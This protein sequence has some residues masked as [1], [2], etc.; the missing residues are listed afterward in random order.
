M[1][2]NLLLCAI[3][4]FVMLDAIKTTYALRKGV[5]QRSLYNWHAPVFLFT[6]EN[7]AGYLQQMNSVNGKKVLT[8]ASSGDH[9]FECM[10]NGAQHIDTFDVNYLQKHVVELKSK[11]IKH[12]SYSDF[13]RFFFDKQSFFSPEII[14]PIWHTFSPGLK[15]FLNKYYS[16]GNNAMFRY[17]KS[18]SSF[19]NVD[20][21]TYIQDPV[22]YEHLGR[23]MPDN[24]N[25]KRTDLTNITN[26]FEETY[27]TILLSNISEYTYEELP[28]SSAKIQLFYDNILMPIAD[29][30]LSKNGG[31]I[32]FNYAWHANRSEFSEIIKHI[33]NNKYS[34]IDCFD[35][36][37]YDIEMVAVPSV[38]SD[39]EIILNPLPD[40]ALYMTQNQR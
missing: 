22:A 18:Q 37:N 16:S 28:N 32:C 12:L 35:F 10:L 39:T 7:I 31:Q 11:M 29:K 30:N 1:V 3:L 20:K 17:R 13:M 21:I 6:N 24:I 23:I 38:C 19:Y 14:K 33:R 4:L 40:I 5:N 34:S 36:M 15:I 8:V 27:D 2:D 26:Q 25:F 9:A